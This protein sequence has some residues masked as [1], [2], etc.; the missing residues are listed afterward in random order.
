MTPSSLKFEVCLAC[1]GKGCYQCKNL[2]ATARLGAIELLLQRPVNELTIL[3]DAAERTVKILVH[4]PL[5]ILAVLGGFLFPYFFASSVFGDF[6]ILDLLTKRDPLYFLF[7]TSLLLSFFFYYRVEQDIEKIKKLPAKGKKVLIENFFSFETHEALK[8]AWKL[9]HKHGHADVM[10]AHLIS[11]LLSTPSL[12]IVFSRLGIPFEIFTEKLAHMVELESLRGRETHLSVAV[13]KSLFRSYEIAVQKKH[14]TISATEVFWAIYLEDKHIQDLFYDFEIDQDAVENVVAWIDINKKLR[15]LWAKRRSRARFK[16]KAHMNRALTARPTYF[17][18]SMGQDFTLL[19][20]SGGFPPLVGREKEV[21]EAF[22]IL[23]QGTGNILLVGE[24]GTGKS[25]ILQGIAELMAAEDVPAE[26]QDKRL[27]VIDPGSLVAA[28]SGVGSIERAMERLIFEI[29]QAGN[30]IL[31]IEDIHELLGARTTGSSADA[32]ELLKNY[33]SEGYLHVLGT[34]TTPEF[35][36]FIEHKETFLRRFQVVKISE[37]LINEAIRVLEARVGAWEYRYKVFFSYAALKAAVDLTERYIQDRHLPAKALD[38]A[39]ETAIFVHENRKEH[40]LVRA[41]DVASV[42]AEKTNVPVE[43]ITESEA[44]KLLSLEEIM[45]QRIVGQEAAVSDISRALRR[46]RE[47][48]RD[49]HRPIATFLFLGPTGVGKTETAK[50]IA[51]VYFGSEE[52]MLRYDMS[53]YQNANSVNRLLDSLAENIRLKPFSLILLDE[54]EKAHLNILNIFLQILDD[55]RI[56]DTSGRTASFVNA[57]IIATSNAG[58]EV[59]QQGIEAGEE[60]QNIEEHLRR[61]TLPEHFR[62]ELL[63]RFDDIVVFRPLTP[64]NMK[65]IAALMIQNLSAQLEKTHGIT[66]NATEG[67]L[68]A[69]AQ[70][71]YDPLYGARPLRRLLQET[72]EDTIAQL[73]LEKRLNRRDTMVIQEDGKL[74]IRH[75]SSI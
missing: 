39:E 55:G 71:G 38:V 21:N 64:G 41:E 15:A 73:L 58:T 7:W 35:Q 8:H 5:L 30:V 33:L 31:A 14:A 60:I 27:V 16:P 75:A 29:V 10:P 6:D 52:E 2:G 43:R 54:F 46:S 62:P 28:G 20:R 59:I 45:H 49:T 1:R 56:T 12:R 37:V 48:I 44:K 32:G 66:L 24:A 68:S 23:K 40:P 69:I 63:N 50:T 70:R 57:M 34:T 18:D 61:E 72:V 9:A 3:Q 51:E 67:A 42:I 26:L 13:K 17:L 47:G 53:E 65:N 36:K 22:R 11:S 74:M 25:T 4:V 19:A